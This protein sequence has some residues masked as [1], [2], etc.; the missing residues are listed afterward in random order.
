MIEEI[1]SDVNIAIFCMRYDFIISK[2][3]L[4]RNKIQAIVFPALVFRP[5]V[6]SMKFI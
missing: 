2:V 5:W 6:I 4:C 3:L 1:L